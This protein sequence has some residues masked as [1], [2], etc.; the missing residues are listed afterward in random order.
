MENIK[1]PTL[2][3]GVDRLAS[4]GG[5]FK[6]SGNGRVKWT[7]QEDDSHL[8]AMGRCT[9]CPFRGTKEQLERHEREHSMSA[10]ELVGMFR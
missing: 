10:E 4:D 6:G 5:F 9:E 1:L 3:E 7:D 2:R 8:K